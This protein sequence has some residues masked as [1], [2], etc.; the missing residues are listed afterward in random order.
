MET[1]LHVSTRWLSLEMVVS[2][3]LRLYKAL[4]SYFG[5]IRKY[6]PSL[7]ILKNIWWMIFPSNVTMYH[8]LCKNVFWFVTSWHSCKEYE[9]VSNHYWFFWMCLFFN[10]TD[11]KQARC[12]RLREVF[13]DPMSE[14]H[15]LFYQSTLIIFTHFNLLFQRQDP[16]VYL[17]HEQV[18]N[19]YCCI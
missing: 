10:S 17:L 7:M 19:T 12:V 2:R 3:I 5:S 1:L 18:H 13:Q 11:E 15:L 4:R 6:K 8:F 14:I 9:N 16:C